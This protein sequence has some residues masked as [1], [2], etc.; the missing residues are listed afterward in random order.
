M[1]NNH[2]EFEEIRAFYD[3][4]V[5]EKLWPL[6][7]EPAIEPFVKAAM[8]DLNMEQFRKQ[9]KSLHT[10]KEFQS[11]VVAKMVL[12]IA[13]KTTDRLELK[14]LD[15]LTP[16]RASLFVTNHRDIVLDSAF[17]NSLLSVNGKETAEIAIGD[18]L[19]AYPWI[20]DLV[21]LNRS[22]VVMRSVPVRQMLEVSKRLSSYIHYT[23]QEKKVSVWIA[24]RE[25]RSKDSSDKT[26]A[27]VIK[28]L[29]MGGESRDLIQNI[30]SL[31]VQPVALSYE[32]DPCDY[33]K[34]QEFQLKRDNPDW[35]KSKEDDVLSMVTGIQGYKGR[36]V[37]TIC[38]EIN[39][40]FDTYPWIDD[41]NAQVNCV[42]ETIDHALHSHM[43]LYPV[44]YVAYNLRFGTD[45][46]ADRYSKDE[47]D[48]VL[49]YLNGQLAKIQIPNRD[50]D[51]LWN[52]LLTMYSNPVVNY[53][54]VKF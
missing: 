37:F 32:Y 5:P 4:D 13:Q 28:M 46:Y 41:R 12:G 50:E 36:V 20:K 8:P 6:V 33:L 18:N 23:I 31:N 42:C 52:C 25:G 39:G 16:G 19:F 35:K 47:E 48:K 17:L 21:R 27:S 29:A 30:R 40:T 34:A 53:E 45:K 2:P 3:E 15:N 11:Q 51:F 9:I 26:Q 38:P 43:V 49:S 10:I 14:G 7:D 1:E 54:N 44:N 24:Q 22:F